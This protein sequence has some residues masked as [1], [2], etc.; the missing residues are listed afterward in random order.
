VPSSYLLHK[1]RDYEVLHKKCGP[2]TPLYQKSIEQ[3]NSGHSSEFLECNYVVWVP[4]NGLGNRILSLTSTFLYAMLTNRVLLVQLTSELDDLFCEPFPDTS[5][6]L[7][8]DFPIKDLHRFNVNSNV[9]YG[10]MLDKH[11]ISNDPQTM[12]KSLPSYVYIHLVENYRDLDKLFFCNDDQIILRKVNWLVLTSDLYFAPSIYTTALFEEELDQLFPSKQS[13]FYLLAHYLIHPSNTVWNL[14]MEYYKSY[15][16]NADEKIGVQVRVFHFTKVS[17]D[18]IFQQILNCSKMESILPGFDLNETMIS[19]SSEQKSKTILVVS[20]YAE[21]YK[22]F[23]SMYNEHSLKTEQFVNVYQPSHEERQ[24]TGNQL[25]NQKALAEIYL[26]SFCDVLV[27]TGISTFGYVSYGLAGIKPVILMPIWDKHIPNLPCVRETSIEPCHLAAA[28]PNCKG[29]T[30][31]K[32]KLKQY[33]KPC[34][35]ESSATK[36]FD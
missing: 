5:W 32:E 12:D 3:L 33:I 27:T 17:S 20:L 2:N 9:T 25:H 1:L 6:I 24:N 15:L 34:P 18:V 36:L 4:Y 30:I 26:L 31:N 28:K 13:T 7:P 22:K 8:H 19:K 29:K 11:V 21:Y 23:K 10:N 14:A 16:A 35:D